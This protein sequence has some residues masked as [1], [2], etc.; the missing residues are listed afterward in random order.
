MKT[1]VHSILK[2][3]EKQFVLVGRCIVKD[4]ERS[5]VTCCLRRFDNNMQNILSSSAAHVCLVEL[6]NDTAD[7]FTM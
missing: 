6:E 1:V 7:T 5:D 3:P 2:A 4:N